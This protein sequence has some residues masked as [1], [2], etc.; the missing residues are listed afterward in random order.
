[1]NRLDANVNILHSK[2][3]CLNYLELMRPLSV[4][5]KIVIIVILTIIY[6]LNPQWLH[7]GSATNMLILGSSSKNTCIRARVL[8][9][10]RARGSGRRRRNSGSSSAGHTRTS[11]PQPASNV[12]GRPFYGSTLTAASGAAASPSTSRRRR[13]TGPITETPCLL[14]DPPHSLTTL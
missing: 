12:R 13:C 7:A 2:R 6:E 11:A 3:I 9:G 4:I 1:M 5:N 8:G 14:V 10:R